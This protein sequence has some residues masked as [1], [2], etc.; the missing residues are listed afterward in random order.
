MASMVCLIDRSTIET[1]TAT[2]KKITNCDLTFM[3]TV[4]L[5]KTIVA[6][7]TTVSKIHII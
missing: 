1:K 5:V 3:P 2:E 6:I 7:E 4:I